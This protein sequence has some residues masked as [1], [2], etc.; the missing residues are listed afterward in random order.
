MTL[1]D[2][3]NLIN[4]SESIQTFAET[5]LL[6][7]A[8]SGDGRYILNYSESILGTP[9]G[10]VSHYCRG[11]T[12]AGEPNNYRIIAKSF[13]RFYNLSE[14]PEYL[15][16]AKEIDFDQPFEV[17]FK[18]DGSLILQYLH[19]GKVSIN[20]RG[21]FAQSGISSVIDQ[22]WE[23]IFNTCERSRLESKLVENPDCTFIYELCTPYNQVVEY[24]PESFAKC[25]GAVRTD[26]TELQNYFEGETYNCENKEQILELLATLKP[27]QEGFVIAQWDED[28]QTYIRK[29]LKTKTWLELSH[30][31]ESALSSNGKLWEV[32]LSGE[33]DEVASVFVHI[34]DQL[35]NMWNQYQDILKFANDEYD[36]VKDIES[37]KDFAIAIKDMEYKHCYFLVRMGKVSMI[38]AIKEYIKKHL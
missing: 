19:N 24:Y 27:T 29:K 20:T 15:V 4:T 26:G 25:L 35:D 18:F 21:S 11:L 17:Q 30:I 37:Q 6:K 33:K 34:K 23:S 13:D 10:W 12:L 16:G 9:K 2:I 7:L 36:S 22:S 32:V 3:L 8:S 14:N 38:T 5:N 1:Q 31:K 28:S